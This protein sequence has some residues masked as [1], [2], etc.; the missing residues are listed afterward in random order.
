MLPILRIIPV[1]GVLLAIMILVL[2][3][4]PPSGLNPGLTPTVRLAR[5]VLMQLG[6]HPE[7][8]QFLLLAATRRADELNRL[9]ELPDM[10]VR[11]DRTKDAGKIAGLPVDRSAAD[12]DDETGSINE[13]PGMTIPIEIGEPS[14]T[15]L[16]VIPLGDKPPI[17]RTPERVKLPSESRRKGVH[18]SRRAKSLAK[19]VPAPQFNGFD[20]L[21]VVPQTK[22]NSGASAQAS[23]PQV[24]RAVP[25]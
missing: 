12:P 6:E 4:S 1:G 11:G 19:T 15:E 2:S 24:D 7:W 9:G 10:P 17:I 8:R 20:P 23:Q 3:L 16:P 22:P 21:F 5:G 13:M 14:S 25:Q 18:Y